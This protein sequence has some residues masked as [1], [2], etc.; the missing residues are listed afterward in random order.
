MDTYDRMTF[1]G[2]VAVVAL[3]LLIMSAYSILTFPR[4]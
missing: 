4:V 1:N 2:W 3:A